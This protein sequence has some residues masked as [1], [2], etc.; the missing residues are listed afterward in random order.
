M[1]TDLPSFTSTD[2]SVCATLESI[3]VAQTLLSVLLQNS[4]ADLKSQEVA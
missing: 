3:N 2:R 1:C 4:A